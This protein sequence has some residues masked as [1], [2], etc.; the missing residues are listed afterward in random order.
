MWTKGENL[1]IVFP[2]P[3]SL[4]HF[5]LPSKQNWDPWVLHV[6]LFRFPLNLFT[7]MI[8]TCFSSKALLTYPFPLKYIFRSLLIPHKP[9]NHRGCALP[10][11]TSAVP[12]AVHCYLLQVSLTAVYFELDSSLLVGKSGCLTEL[13]EQSLLKSTHSKLLCNIKPMTLLS[14]KATVW[15]IHYITIRTRTLHTQRITIS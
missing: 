1:I 10:P 2:A 14:L 3:W 9:V 4:L 12:I 13:S 5:P 8:H 15:G 7:V 11:F 6:I